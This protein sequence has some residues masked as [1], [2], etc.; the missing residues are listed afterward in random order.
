MVKE[1]LVWVHGFRGIAACLSGEA[2]TAD[3]V[4]SVVTEHGVDQKAENGRHSKASVLVR[5]TVAM[6]KHHEQKQLEKGRVDSAYS[7]T[8]LFAI[9]GS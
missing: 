2:T 3:V 7:S 1:S 5:V 8:P 9:K 6:M 4:G